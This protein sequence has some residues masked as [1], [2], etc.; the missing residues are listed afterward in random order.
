M[1]FKVQ[2]IKPLVIN[3]SHDEDRRTKAEFEIISYFLA[4]Y[5]FNLS[6]KT[7]FIC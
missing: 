4:L 6:Q 3:K 7:H 1:L 5:F 2:R